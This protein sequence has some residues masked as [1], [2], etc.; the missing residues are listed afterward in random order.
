MAEPYPTSR[1]ELLVA[2]KRVEDQLDRLQY[3][4]YAPGPLV[5]FRADKVRL[6]AELEAILAEIKAELAEMDSKN[7]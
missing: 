3:G 5:G 1:K 6:R 2:R 4:G 7:A